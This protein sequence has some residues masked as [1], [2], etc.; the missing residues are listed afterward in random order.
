MD[1]LSEVGGYQLITGASLPPKNAF[2]FS[3]KDLHL[4]ALGRHCLEAVYRS[5]CPRKVILPHYTCHSV[6]LQFI[7]LGAEVINY[8]LGDEFVPEINTIDARDLLVIN[9]Y[10]GLAANNTYWFS[11]L[12]QLNHKQVVVDDTQSLCVAGQFDKYCSFISPRKFLPVTDGGILFAASN[13]INDSV[14][15]TK[16]DISWQRVQWLFRAIDEHGRKQSYAEYLQYRKHEIQNIQYASMSTVT[17]FL[18]RT[19][20]VN[21][22]IESRNRL[23]DALRQLLPI[24]PLFRNISLSPLASPIGFPVKVSD[25]GKA[26]SSLAGKKIYSVRYWPELID[27]NYLSPIELELVLHTIFLPLDGEYSDAHISTILEEVVL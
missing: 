20:D 6:K 2:N 26:Q 14:L 24:H 10:F 17:K 13:S 4:F 21:G 18:L 1:Q 25:T 7:R 11:W 12:K 5:L 19:Y 8:S 22:V 3:S 16:D 9:N 23:F 27:S 15:P